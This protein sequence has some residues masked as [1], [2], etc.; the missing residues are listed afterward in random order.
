MSWEAVA[1]FASGALGAG[2]GYAGAMQSANLSKKEA[3]KQ[4]KWQERMSN[5]AYQRM[6]ADLEAAGLNPILAM[7]RGGAS[8]PPGA[9]AHV[10]DFGKAGAAGASSA[11]SLR[12]EERRLLK[13]QRNRT[14]MESV[15]TA[16][17]ADVAHQQFKVLSKE[18][19][20]RGQAAERGEILMRLYRRHP[21]LLQAKEVGPVFTGAAKALPIGRAANSAARSLMRMVPKG[22]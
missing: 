18:A 7:P 2:L 1:D 11:R 10:P 15:K 12:L 5:T 13:E 14:E 3:K 8:S 6:A 22:K 21:E 20:I 17:E 19:E 16:V 4:R 9:M